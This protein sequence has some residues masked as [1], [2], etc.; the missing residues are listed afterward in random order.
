MQRL[1]QHAY[2]RRWL[3]RYFASEVI[4]GN[5]RPPHYLRR[6]LTYE[7]ILWL[8]ERAASRWNSIPAVW[9]D[10]YFLAMYA[11]DRE[12]TDRESV[13]RVLGVI[14]RDAPT[15]PEE[16]EKTKRELERQE[17]EI[18]EERQRRRGNIERHTIAEIVDQVLHREDWTDVNRMRQL[19]LLCFSGDIRRYQDADGNWGDLEVNQQRRVL[20]ACQNGLK[21]GTPTP[22]PDGKAFTTWNLAEAQAFMAVLTSWPS[23]EWFD[24]GMIEKW[25]P[26]VLR[27]HVPNA[28]DAVIACAGKDRQATTA[29]AIAMIEEEVTRGENHMFFADAIPV[30]LWSGEVA[31]RVARFA[32]DESLA[33]STCAGLLEL[34]AAYA[35]SSAL[36]LAVEWTENNGSEGGASV[37]YRK[38]LDVRLAVDPQG[39]WPLIEVAYQRRGGDALR[40]LSS[41]WQRQADF[42]ANLSQWSTSQ[43]ERLAQILLETFPLPAETEHPPEGFVMMGTDD[44]L[45]EVRNR[46]ISTLVGRRLDGDSH[47]LASLF[48][49][50]PRLRERFEWEKQQREASRMLGTL[51]Q[52][53]A[54]ESPFAGTTGI[55][56]EQVVRLLD[57]AD[58]RLI[59]SGDDLLKA[60]I[61][62]LRQVDEDAPYD[63]S[64]LYGRNEPE[65][66]GRGFKP[67]TK[68]AKV[69]SPLEEDAL[70]AYVRRRLDDMLPP[71]TRNPDQNI[72]RAGGQIST[73]IRFGGCGADHRS[74]VGKSRSRDQVV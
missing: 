64:M 21:D 2:G 67:K 36:P 70:Q 26:S 12:T 27:T 61:H 72:L 28:L 55:P 14:A 16:F 39:A 42:G 48:E 66:R 17:R 35:S 29:V 43:L 44:E 58:Y 53:V 62:V 63:L 18:Q 23:G 25:L 5:P 51:V 31:Q 20:E 52:S 11:P 73:P 45:K 13:D 65:M 38:A 57:E 74:T 32:R 19:S 34:L 54:S 1:R 3:Y 68:K 60:L 30:E 33:V 50:E 47:A 37:L 15:I 46:V 6:I 8:L 9:A 69:R 59:R 49:I 41:L 40:D 71:H 7:D 24:A 56:V 4:K 10:L 22:F